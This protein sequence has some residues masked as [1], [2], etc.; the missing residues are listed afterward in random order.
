MT[1]SS[2]DHHR[3]SEARDPAGQRH[4]TARGSD[5]NRRQGV[6]IG[7]ASIALS[8]FDR[9]FAVVSKRSIPDRRLSPLETTR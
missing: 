7:P 9:H 1:S 8:E 6:S 5:F 2:L 3:P 4:G